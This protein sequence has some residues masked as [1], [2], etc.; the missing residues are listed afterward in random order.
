LGASFS[1]QTAL[2]AIFDWIFRD[3]AQTF[4][5]FAQISRDFAHIFDKSKL[6]GV[7]LHTLHPRLLHPAHKAGF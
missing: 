3:F 2:D 4:R 5:D 6:L 1:N 7:Q